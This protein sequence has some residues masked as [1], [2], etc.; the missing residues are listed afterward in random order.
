[1]NKNKGCVNPSDVGETDLV[2]Y[3]ILS[4][5]LVKVNFPHFPVASSVRFLHLLCIAEATKKFRSF[6]P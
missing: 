5:I 6:D 2:F 3:I 1:M 4:L